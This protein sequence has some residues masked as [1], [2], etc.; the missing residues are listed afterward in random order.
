MSMM[1]TNPFVYVKLA[2]QDWGGFT[3]CGA[4]VH[5]MLH[6]LEV[7]QAAIGN[8]QLILIG[9]WNA[10]LARWSLDQRSDPV[11]GVLNDK[12]RSRGA[13]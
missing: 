1:F 8:G 11:G 13:K 9:D 4:S 5:E 12:R 2:G 7:I 3:E 6:L 10:Y